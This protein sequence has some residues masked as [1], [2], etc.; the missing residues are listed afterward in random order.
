M[1]QYFRGKAGMQADQ[2]ELLGRECVD[3]GLLADIATRTCCQKCRDMLPRGSNYVH[4]LDRLAVEGVL[5]CL[6]TGQPA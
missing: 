3:V 5:K 1:K 2:Q 4:Q 6:V